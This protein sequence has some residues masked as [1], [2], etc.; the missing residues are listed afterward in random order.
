MCSSDLFNRVATLIKKNS[1]GLIPD[2]SGL[3]EAEENFEKMHKS[4]AE[5]MEKFDFLNALKSIWNYIS[6]TNKFITDAKPW[7]LTDR[8]EEHTS[9]LQSHSFI[10]YAVFCLKKK[11]KK[12]KK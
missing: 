1:S 3:P 2:V 11:K 9:E 8:S 5:S 4:A 10:S 6:W 12:V 7:A